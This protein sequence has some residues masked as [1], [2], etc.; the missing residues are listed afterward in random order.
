MTRTLLWHDYET[1][2]ANPRL[3][4]PAQFAAIRTD[5][6]F[7]PI[8]E[9]LM[10]Y[11]QPPRD[12]LPH[13]EAA[14][15][16]GITPQQALEAGLPEPEFMAR[17]H[18]EMSQPG[19]CSVG[20]NSLRFDDE[21]TRHGLWR[22]FFDP[23]ARE[24]KNGCSRWDIIDMVRL[25][26][27]LRPD[28]IQWPRHEDGSPSF[29]LE[30]LA[31][32]NQLEQ[33]RAHDALSDVRA[34]IAL[35]KL[36]REH[37]PKLYDFVFSN[38]DK[39]SAAAM[40]NL[41]THRPVLHVS[42]RFPAHNGCISLVM[43]LIEH[44]VNGNAVICYDLRH[45]PTDLI[46]LTL[47][48]IHDRLFVPA[49]ELPDGVERIALK[50]VHINKCPVLAP[51]DMLS[52]DEAR[53]LNLD[54]DRLRRHRSA[55]VDNLETVAA[56]AAAVFALGEQEAAGDPEQALYDG[57]TGDD[58]RRLCDEV[59]Q[60][61][62][63][64]LTADAVRFKDARLAEMLFRYRARYA[65]Q[66]LDDIERQ[67]WENWRRN[68]IEFAPDGGLDYARYNETI[69]MLMGQHGSPEA[70]QLLLALKRWGDDLMA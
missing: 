4:R 65:P 63:A 59:R 39:R 20:Y 29:K 54:G 51:A 25:T 52:P 9:P 38:R 17:I 57:F 49:S 2:G 13:P 28:G 30:S 21:V 14:L 48:D 67:E 43:P 61:D 26:Y 31:G 12:L 68:R 19:T 1:F 6:D 42:S 45:D 66:T 22:N 50:G 55:I 44:P 60:S 35:A 23:Y 32:A 46:E 34:T 18:A 7:N 3:D 15:I 69:E 41:Q 47:E 58:D 33:A 16:T 27:A 37:Q 62:P 64:A 11:C 5:L 10:F 36:V 70:L 53:R 24:W 56:K 8:G 40:L